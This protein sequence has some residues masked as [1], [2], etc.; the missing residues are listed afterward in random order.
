MPVSLLKGIKRRYLRESLPMS[1]KYTV[2]P[3]DFSKRSRSK[4]SKLVVMVISEVR[5]PRERHLQQSVRLV[6]SAENSL[7]TIIS[8]SFYAEIKG[9]PTCPAAANFRRNRTRL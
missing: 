3:P 2:R 4:F 6:D 5:M 9:R 1:P 7:A 8:Q